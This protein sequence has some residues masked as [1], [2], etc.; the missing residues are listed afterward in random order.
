MK[1][2]GPPNTRPPCPVNQPG[3]GA[4]GRQKE[5]AS[6]D[7]FTCVFLEEQNGLFWFWLLGRKAGRAREATSPSPPPWGDATSSH[8]GRGPGPQECVHALPCQVP[9]R[10]LAAVTTQ[11][12]EEATAAS[13]QGVGRWDGACA[14]GDQYSLRAEVAPLAV[15]HGLG[16]LCSTWVFLH[17]ANGLLEVGAWGRNSQKTAESSRPHHGK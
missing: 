8:S 2:Q 14:V 16:S 7:L 4:G 1:M 12:P 11:G 9:G 5:S 3:G 13:V 10:T 17:K 15:G 6:D